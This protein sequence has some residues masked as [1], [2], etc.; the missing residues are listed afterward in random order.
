MF[1]E[2]ANEIFKHFGTDSFVTDITKLATKVLGGVSPAEYLLLAIVSPLVYEFAVD[3]D[4]INDNNGVL[5]G[6]GTVEFGN[7]I[8]NIFSSIT[9]FF[10]EIITYLGL[11][12]TVINN[13]LS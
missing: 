11:V 8:S 6:Y 7:N 13:M 10:N 3:N 5:P 4:G 9:A 1:F 2:A 12:V